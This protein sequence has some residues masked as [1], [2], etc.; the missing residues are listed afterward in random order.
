MLRR[1]PGSF[2][3]A[4]AAD[5]QVNLMRRLCGV[6]GG[7]VAQSPDRPGVIGLVADLDGGARLLLDIKLRPG[8]PRLGNVVAAL[9]RIVVAQNGLLARL[10][11]DQIVVHCSLPTT[12]EKI[13]LSRRSGPKTRHET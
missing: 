8:E 12:T 13:A 5:Q 3:S 6:G 7:S 10:E 11:I 4:A 2:R 1:S 9:R